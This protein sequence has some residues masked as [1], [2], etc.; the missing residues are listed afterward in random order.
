MAGEDAL[1]AHR[2]VLEQW[3]RSMDLVGPG[4]LDPHFEDAEQAVCTLAAAVE[5]A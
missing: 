3:R 5:K 1:A 4:P 2:R